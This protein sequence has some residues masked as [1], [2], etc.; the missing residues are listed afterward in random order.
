MNTIEDNGTNVLYAEYPETYNDNNYLCK[1]TFI[2][3]PK[4]GLYKISLTGSIELENSYNHSGRN[5]GWKWEDSSTGHRFTSAG[6]HSDHNRNNRF[7]R[8]RYEIQLVRDFGKGDFNTENKTIVGYYF[9]PNNPQNNVF[10]GDSPENYP[11]YFPRPLRAQ[12][13]DASTDESFING[14]HWGRVDNNSDYN[15]QGTAVNYMFIKMVI[16]GINSYSQSNKI[17]SAYDCDSYWCYGTD[18]DATI[19]V[20]EE[21][22]EEIEGGDDNVVLAWRESN[23]Y[24][25]KLSGSQN[26]ISHS[27]EYKGTGMLNH[28]VYLEK[29]EHITVLFVGEGNDLRRNTD[30]TKMELGVCLC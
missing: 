4:S 29:G 6:Q 8:K 26:Q 11:K 17:Y 22:G 28:I 3:I 27:G 1:S 14:F 12:L 5:S 30:H 24:S 23:K 16:V 7:G 10:N 20:D 21:T 19:E 15:P 18:D 9:R 25:A 13:I 2:T